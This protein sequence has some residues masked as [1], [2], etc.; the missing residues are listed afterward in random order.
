[1]VV[2]GIILVLDLV[3]FVHGSAEMFPTETQ[4]SDIRWITGLVAVFLFFVEAALCLLLRRL[5]RGAM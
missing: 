5:R 1:M 3:Y 2:V 4:H